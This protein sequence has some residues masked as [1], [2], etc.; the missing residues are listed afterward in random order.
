MFG[1]L[2]LKV[3]ITFEIYESLVAFLSQVKPAD[4]VLIASLIRLMGWSLT[5]R[6]TIYMADP[7]NI[8]ICAKFLDGLCLPLPR[9]YQCLCLLPSVLQDLC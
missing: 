7:A 4:L 9:H 6:L 2:S 1:F 3:T 8:R 5:N